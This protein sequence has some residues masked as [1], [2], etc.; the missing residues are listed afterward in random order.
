VIL[1]PLP[2][3]D[4]GHPWKGVQDLLAAVE[5]KG[6]DAKGVFKQLGMSAAAGH[7]VHVGHFNLVG[8][9]HPLDAKEGVI[10]RGLLLH[11]KGEF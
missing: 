4:G 10:D 3:S 5:T 9:G 7:Q 8:N 11:G 1:Q 2:R 6:L